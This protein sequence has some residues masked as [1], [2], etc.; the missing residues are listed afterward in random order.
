MA[1]ASRIQTGTIWVN[2]HMASPSDVP[3]S[4]MDNTTF[5]IGGELEISRLGFGAMRL[6][7]PGIWGQPT[8]REAALAT[9]R[10]VP[11]SGINSIDTADSY[12]PDVSEPSIREASHPYAPGMHIATKAGL[13]RPGP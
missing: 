2:Q 3:G 5:R 10:R 13:R 7:G 8:D 9:L 12:G 1:V 4:A 11:E 6:T